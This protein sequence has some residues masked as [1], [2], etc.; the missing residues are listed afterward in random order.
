MNVVNQYGAGHPARYF[1]GAEHNSRRGDGGRSY[2]RGG[3][4]K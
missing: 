1:G 4:R 2:I 3:G